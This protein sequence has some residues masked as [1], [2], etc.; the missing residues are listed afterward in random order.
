[1]YRNLPAVEALNGD[2]LARI[3]T[4]IIPHRFRYGYL[5]FARE[6]GCHR[7]S[8]LSEIHLDGMA[9]SLV[10]NPPV[11]RLGHGHHYNRSILCRVFP[12]LSLL[13]RA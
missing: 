9:E 5:P 2:T 13:P 8:V 12:N 7:T 10:S 1:M 6:I 4:Q 11:L 3:E